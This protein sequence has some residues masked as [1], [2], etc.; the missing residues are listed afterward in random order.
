MGKHSEDRI[1]WAKL[2]KVLSQCNREQATVDALFKLME[3]EEER[4][5]KM[6]EFLKALEQ[7][8]RKDKIKYISAVVGGKMQ[9]VVTINDPTRRR[10]KRDEIKNDN[11]EQ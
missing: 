8:E 7:L 9:R 1:H 2:K 10:R 5:L 3:K 4:P 6:S 11:D